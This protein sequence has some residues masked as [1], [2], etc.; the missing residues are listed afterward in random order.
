MANIRK[1]TAAAALL[2]LIYVLKKKKKIENSKKLK[3]KRRVWANKFLLKRD[4]YC[5]ENKLL[6]DLLTADGKKYHNFL[7]LSHEQFLELHEQVS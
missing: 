6:T 4:L 1:V 2:L 3:R 7:R 5:M